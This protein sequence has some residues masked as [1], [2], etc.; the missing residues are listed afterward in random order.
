MD[1]ALLFWA[2]CVPTRYY[3]ATVDVP[4]KR[5]A[6]LIVAMRWLLGYEDGHVGFFGGEA[7]WANERKLHGMFWAAYAATGVSTYLLADVWLGAFNW[8]IHY[9]RRQIS[10]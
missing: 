7:W 5:L 8:I 3:I 10:Q 1:R 9:R 6:A 4:E 2:V